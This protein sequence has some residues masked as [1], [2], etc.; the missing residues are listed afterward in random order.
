M[1]VLSSIRDMLTEEDKIHLMPSVTFQEELENPVQAY[2]DP[3]V[4]GL[5]TF[6]AHLPGDPDD[7]YEEK[8][9]YISNPGPA[10]RDLKAGKLTGQNRKWAIEVQALWE[11]GFY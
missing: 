11:N 10:I 5:R 6:Y 7:H 8:N 1:K 4:E 9:P 3:D 2:A